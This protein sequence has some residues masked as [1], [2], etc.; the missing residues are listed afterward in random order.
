MCS[1]DLLERV[2]IIGKR[3]SFQDDLAQRV[4][5]TLGQLFQEGKALAAQGL[6]LAAQGLSLLDIPPLKDFQGRVRDYLDAKAE[7]G[8]LSEAETILF[9][10]LYAANEVLMPT[11]VLDFA[12]SIGKG[13]TAA[14][15]AI[16]LGRGVDELAQVVRAESKVAADEVR[17]ARAELASVERWA[18]RETKYVAE[19]GKWIRVPE[20]AQSVAAQLEASLER[21]GQLRPPGGNSS[22][23]HIVGFAKE[24]K[25]AQEALNRFGITPNDG[26]NGIWLSKEMHQQTFGPAYKDWVARKFESVLTESDARS[27]LRQI[28]GTLRAGKTPWKVG[29]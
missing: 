22:P 16:R 5:G 27:V 4:G 20:G 11:N 9:A 19:D 28:E 7:A 15:G 21:A 25:L 1:S 14:V 17:L 2:V 18:A 13:M 24:D 10:T 8:G 26:A 29:G 6:E 12:G 23:H 3:H